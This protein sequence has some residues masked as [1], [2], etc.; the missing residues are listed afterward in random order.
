LA[1]AYALHCTWIDPLQKIR[2]TLARYRRAFARAKS[3]VDGLR[4]SS[5]GL[6]RR[7][8]DMRAAFDGVDK[9]LLDRLRRMPP[10]AQEALVD[11][12]EG[13]AMAALLS[14]V[15]HEAALVRRIAQLRDVL[16]G[17][18][19]T[20]EEKAQALAANLWLFAPDWVVEGHAF[21]NQSLR[22]VVGGYF[23]ADD[24]Q[25][26]TGAL[27]DR[28]AGVAALCRRRNGIAS[29]S[30]PG[31]LTLVLVFTDGAQGPVTQELLDGAAAIG[32]ALKRRVAS[33]AAIPVMS[34]VVG[35]GISGTVKEPVQDAGTAGVHVAAATWPA[36][37]QKAEARLSR[38]VDLG[39]IRI[40]A[41]APP[42]YRAPDAEP[43][44]LQAAA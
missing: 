32:R 13:P 27:L 11:L 24:V 15:R 14:N 33:L 39:S 28:K 25:Y 41:D 1:V 40:N 43:L 34:L 21:V 16:T 6:E 37:V 17:R 35:T 19:A 36:L 8:A 26:S 18:G 10:A 2:G 20:P 29:A 42:V 3:E 23:P 5:V 22:T 30:D 38:S 31:E 12:A 7:I 9:S 4:A 44:E